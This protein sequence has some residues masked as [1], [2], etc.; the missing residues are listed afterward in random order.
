MGGLCVGLVCV[1]IYL[2]V[3]VSVCVLCTHPSIH[4]SNPPTPL[5]TGLLKQSKAEI[6]LYVRAV[7]V[8]EASLEATARELKRDKYLGDADWNVVFR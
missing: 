4:P 7:S 6:E 8:V 2:C 3:C 5:P 1:Y